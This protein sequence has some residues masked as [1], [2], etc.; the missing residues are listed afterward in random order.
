MQDIPRVLGDVIERNARYYPGKCA[1]VCEDRR[2]T[3]AEFAARVRRI[4]NALVAGGLQRQARF[5]ILAQN[6]IE[7]FEAVG[8]AELTGF[9]AVTLNWRLSPQELA[10]IVD[11]CTPTVLIFEAQFTAQAEMLRQHGIER[12]IVIGD[13]PDW[14]ERYEQVLAAAS[15]SRPALRPDPEDGVYLIYTSGS[16]GQPK[17]VLLSHRAILSAGLIISWE[18]GVRPTDRMLIVMPLFHIGGKINQI[19]NMLAGAT[20]F[21]HRSFDAGA[22]LCC[23]EN[24]RITTAHFAP[25]MVRA[26]LDH[27]DL[28]RTRK[29]SLRGIQYASAPM[30]VAQLRE[31]M[32]AFGPIFTQVYGMTECVVGTILQAHDHLPDG[33]PAQVRRLA[34]AGQPFF[35]HAIIVAR[36]DGSECAP[37]EIGEVLIKGP[38]LM[39]GYWNNSAATVETTRDGWMHTGDIGFFD[40]E[41]FLFIVDRKKDMI[42]SGGENIY[43]REVEEALL[44][45]PAV[46]AAAVVGVPDARWGES[47][48][49]CVVLRP[50]GR[51]SEDDLIQHCRTLI[52]SYKKPRSVDFVDA[53]PRLFNGK[54]DKK[55]LRAHYWQDQSRQVS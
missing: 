36:A 15:D 31:A 50:E 35:D 32:A 46:L 29:D 21:L 20:I 5:A 41:A 2:V 54:V 4:A 39:T 22:M 27:P 44:T 47:V 53:L 40:S 16:T 24:E 8:A 1:V 42:V 11:D 30:A 17:G 48:K 9:I 43:S 10:Q 37:E 38:S 33:T 51:A 28:I 6:C 55:A 12:C 23:I 49:A 7:Y 25:V 52:A 26:M 45:H 34:S 18:S 19:A 14:A 3:Y 13:G